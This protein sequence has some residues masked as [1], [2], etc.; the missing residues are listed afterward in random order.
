MEHQD[1]KQGVYECIEFV[2]CH[3]TNGVLL[4][5]NLEI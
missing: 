4:N 5:G 2:K 1:L 3:A